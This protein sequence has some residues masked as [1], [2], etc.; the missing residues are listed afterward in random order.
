MAGRS[1][2]WQR[3][4]WRPATRAVQTLMDDLAGAVTLTAAGASWREETID[5][6]T[7]GSDTRST[8]IGAGCVHRYPARRADP[9][10]RSALADERAHCR[11]VGDNT[12]E[13]VEPHRP[14]RLYGA[15]R[16]TRS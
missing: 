15:D 12:G 6:L 11:C 8:A 16:R 13:R 2:R 7:L 1:W 14:D 4:S 9:A 5:F 10:Q 3:I